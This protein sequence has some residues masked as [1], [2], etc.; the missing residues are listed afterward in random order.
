[1]LVLDSADQQRWQREDAA[2]KQRDQRMAALTHEIESNTI[3]VCTD[4]GRD[5][6][7]LLAQMGRPLPCAELQ[8]RLHLC[9]RNLIFERSINSPEKTGIY[10]ELNVRNPAGG[11]DKQKKFL[12]GM[13]S[14]ISPEFSVKHQT[15]KRVPNPDVVACG[16]KAVPREACEWLEIPT[17]YAETRG[18]RTVLLRLLHLKLITRGDVE[19]Y[20]DWN[21]THESEAWHGSTNN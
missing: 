14:G 18:W 21:P 15:I 7:N 16:G 6:S 10:F 19:R 17:F 1:M 11:W 2:S 9:N 3:S 12:F 4:A 20:F 5:T 8:R 13:E